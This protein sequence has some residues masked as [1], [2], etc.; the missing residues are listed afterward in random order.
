MAWFH[1]VLRARDVADVVVSH[2]SSKVPQLGKGIWMAWNPAALAVV[3]IFVWLIVRFLS[4]LSEI[5][6]LSM[7]ALLFLGACYVAFFLGCGAAGSFQ[8]SKARVRESVYPLPNFDE[9]TYWITAAMGVVGIAVRQYDRV[10]LRGV[11]FSAGSA[12]VREALEQAAASGFGM[13]GAILLP[14]CLVPLIIVLSAQKLRDRKILLILAFGIFLLPTLETIGQLSRSVLLLTSA[15]LVLLIILVRLKGRVFKLGVIAPGILLSCVALLLS[16]Y[17]FQTRLA[18][19]GRTF[20]ESVMFS[21]YAEQIGASSEALRGLFEGGIVEST[22]YAAVLPNA[23]YYVSGVYEFSELWQRPDL[24]EHAWGGYTFGPILRAVNF[25]LG[26]VIASSVSEVEL[27]YRLGVFNTFFG[28]VWIDFGWFGLVFM[29]LFGF[30]VTRL[31]TAVRAGEQHW[32]PLYIFSACITFYMPVVNFIQ[33]GFG[34]FFIISFTIFGVA[35]EFLR[36][37]QL[38]RR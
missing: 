2:P 29:S 12:A 15:C 32:L 1:R 22:F 30:G 35:V 7:D 25:V 34:L 27:V 14:F 21:V 3:G 31:S 11:D 16:T 26:D 10:V 33:S 4:P 19:A 38:H 23:M 20:D 18:D 24:Q 13:V 37:N 5:T 17:M 6:P 8:I 36:Q 28:P 9:R